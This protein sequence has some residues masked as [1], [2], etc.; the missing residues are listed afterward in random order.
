MSAALLQFR[1]VPRAAD[2]PDAED[3]ARRYG[4][5]MDQAEARAAAE[6]H[7]LFARGFAGEAVKLPD[8]YV[9][10]DD[11]WVRT[12]YQA[13]AVAAQEASDNVAAFRVLLAV[14][15]AHKAGQNV[16]PLLDQFMSAC[17]D[18]Y[19][20]DHAGDLAKAERD[21]AEADAREWS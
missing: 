4:D 19:A 21:A 9:S 17:A 10:R 16:G 1:A 5:L 15:K 8:A 6:I 13:F 7:E 20:A 3:R 18:A 2:R 11:V 12:E 14:C